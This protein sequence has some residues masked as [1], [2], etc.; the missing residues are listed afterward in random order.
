MKDQCSDNFVIHKSHPLTILVVSI[1]S[2]MFFP[3]LQVRLD[4]TPILLRLAPHLTVCPSIQSWLRI[5]VFIASCIPSH[6]NREF[7]IDPLVS[8]P[9]ACLR[10]DG[11]IPP[12]LV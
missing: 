10:E 5:F 9:K 6:S 11:K 2:G 1:I 12:W 3:A 7:Y 8:F 4:I